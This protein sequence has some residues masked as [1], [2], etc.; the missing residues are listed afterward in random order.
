MTDTD[1]V[2]SGRCASCMLH[3]GSR[4]SDERVMKHLTPYPPLL[5]WQP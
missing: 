5:F 1:K 3:L 4:Q 2:V